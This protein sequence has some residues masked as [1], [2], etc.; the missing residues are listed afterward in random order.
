MARV[1]TMSDALAP[2]ESVDLDRLQEHR[3]GAGV[4]TDVGHEI[5][6]VVEGGA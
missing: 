2:P 4:V 5:A 3:L 1:L 6:E